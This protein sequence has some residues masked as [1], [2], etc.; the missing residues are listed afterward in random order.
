MNPIIRAVAMNKIP[1]AF[2]L[3]MF[4][5]VNTLINSQIKRIAARINIGIKVVDLFGAW[6]IENKSNKSFVL[7]HK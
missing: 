4:H 3:F 5:P 1:T 6:I 7:S 2:V